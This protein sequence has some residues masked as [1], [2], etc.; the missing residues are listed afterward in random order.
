MLLRPIIEIETKMFASRVPIL[1]RALK[2][3][4]SVGASAVK[5]TT[6]QLQIIKHSGSW[7]YRTGVTSH[8]RKVIFFQQLLGG[9]K[10][11]FYCYWLSRWQHFRHSQ[12]D[13]FFCSH[14]VVDF[15]AFMARLWSH[16]RWIPVPATRTMDKC[17]IG[18]TTRRW[19]R[20]DSLGVFLNKMV[21]TRATDKMN[22]WFD[23]EEIKKRLID[24][25]ECKFHFCSVCEFVHSVK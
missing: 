17:R 4:G 13:L 10:Y 1:C 22:W 20:L 25:I 8:S 19:R 21:R 14:V 9:C 3:V 18:Y 24:W 2:H 7:T 23:K 16:C 12:F 6:P 15:L 11:L 5:S